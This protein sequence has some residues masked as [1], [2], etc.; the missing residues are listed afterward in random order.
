VLLGSFAECVQ[1]N[2]AGGGVGTAVRTAAPASGFAIGVRATLMALKR[3][4]ARFFL[5]YERTR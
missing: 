5:P 2:V 4:F 1:A 3:V